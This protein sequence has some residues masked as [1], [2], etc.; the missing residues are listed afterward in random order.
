MIIGLSSLVVG[1]VTGALVRQRADLH[2]LRVLR[3]DT[4][5]SQITDIGEQVC[6]LLSECLCTWL[7]VA[8]S[9]FEEL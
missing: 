8:A 2:D 4:V 5:S 3:I 6:P 7:R 1:H 9:S